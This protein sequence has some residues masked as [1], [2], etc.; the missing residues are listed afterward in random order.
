MVFVLIV[1]NDFGKVIGEG[2]DGLCPPALYYV[3]ELRLAD[4][5]L[6]ML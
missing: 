1:V 2:G 5:M 3:L 4:Q 6:A